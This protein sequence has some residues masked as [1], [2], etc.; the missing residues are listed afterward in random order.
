MGQAKYV[1][2]SKE[3]TS[4]SLIIINAANLTQMVELQRPTYNKY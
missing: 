1:K 2:A 4:H 3:Q